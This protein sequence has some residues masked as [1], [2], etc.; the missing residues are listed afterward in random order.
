[1]PCFDDLMPLLKIASTG[2]VRI[3]G[4]MYE[5]RVLASKALKVLSNSSRIFKVKK[6]LLRAGSN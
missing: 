5:D 1:M 4:L 6:F 2:S 3:L